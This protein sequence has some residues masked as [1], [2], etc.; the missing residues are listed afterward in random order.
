M[1]LTYGLLEY[2]L[3][4]FR[5]D[6]DLEFSRLNMEFT[7]SRPKMVRLSRNKKQT[8]RLKSKPQM[9]PS[10]LTWA[11]TLISNFQGEIWNSLY[12]GKKWSDCNEIK[13]KHIDWTLCL[14]CDHI[15]WPWPWA[16][17]WIFKVKYGIHYSLAKNGMIATKQNQ[18]YRLNTTPH[19]WPSDLTLAVSLTLNIQGQ[20]WN[21]LYHGQKWSNCHEAKT[22]H[23]DWTRC[24][25]C[26][27][28]ID[29]H[30]MK[31]RI[32]N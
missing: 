30:K 6:L 17:P 10:D 12:L 32:W 19:M 26:D 9:W 2:I 4:D 25:N 23:I 28:R 3:V 24:L 7:I 13:S 27:H 18:T 8:Y 5:C 11:M 21:L 14:K 16:W 31:V 22:K 1:D 29:C 15:I 20:I